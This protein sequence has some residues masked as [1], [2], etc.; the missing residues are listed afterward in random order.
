MPRPEDLP[1]PPALPK[2]TIS[3]D[4]PQDASE[5][6]DTLPS[7]PGLQN[8]YTEDNENPGRADANSLLIGMGDDEEVDNGNDDDADDDERMPVGRGGMGGNNSTLDVSD[9]YAGLGGAF[10]SDSAAP[11]SSQRGRQQEDLLL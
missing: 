11:A 4:H 8:R 3:R 2:T 7:V 10:G 6:I 1:L 9:P 5:E